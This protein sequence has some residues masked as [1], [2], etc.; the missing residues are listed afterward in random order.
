MSDTGL[1][2]RPQPVLNANDLVQSMGS[3]YAFDVTTRSGSPFLTGKRLFARAL[4]GTP[5]GIICD[6]AG[7]VFAGCGDGVEIW[8][9][10][11]TLLG[12]IRVPG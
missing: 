3:I 1:R 11:G 10:G 12:V 6:S 8:N 2:P 9:P 7:N 4:S 5:K